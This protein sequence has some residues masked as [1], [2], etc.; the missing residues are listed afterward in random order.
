MFHLATIER[1]SGNTPT[2]SYVST[3]K[4]YM[5]SIHPARAEHLVMVG[6]VFGEVYDII[7]PLNAEIE[8][9]DRLRVG[10]ESYIV[11]GKEDYRK[12]PIPHISLVVVKE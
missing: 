11:R 6:G 9:G 2:Q 10:G 3:G 4:S 5:V 12:S 1:K 7:A 8:I